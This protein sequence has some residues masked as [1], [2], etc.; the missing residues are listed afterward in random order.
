MRNPWPMFCV[1]AVT[2]LL[3]MS[4]PLHTVWI[5]VLA[6]VV[7]FIA[8]LIVPIK[9]DDLLAKKI[10]PY[11]LEYQENH[12][13]AKLESG[14]KR[15]RP[16]AITKESKN[17]I[18][19]NWF[20]ALLEQEQWEESRKVLEQIKQKAKTTVDWMNYHLLMAEYAKK[21]GDE[22]L[23]KNEKELSD[24]LKTK[25]EHKMQNPKESATAKQCKKS[26]FLWLSFALFLIISGCVCVFLFQ[27]SILGDLGASAVLVSFFALPV[28][29]IWFIIWMIRKQKEKSHCEK[30]AAHEHTNI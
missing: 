23:E 29:L 24:L 17:A 11:I 9:F 8:S 1:L 16:W 28:A 22:Q 27:E 10:N 21:I 7:L 30:E 15:W 25:I 12:D 5:I 18:Q 26:F 13:L 14:L 20:C 2:G 3:C 4:F 19:L 6:V